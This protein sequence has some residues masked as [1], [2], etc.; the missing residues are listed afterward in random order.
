MTKYAR[1]RTDGAVECRFQRI[2]FDLPCDIPTLAQQL[3]AALSP[4]TGMDLSAIQT[5]PGTTYADVGLR[6]SLFGGQA[7]L[8]VRA[9]RS[10]VAFSRLVLDSEILLALECAELVTAA[11][12]ECWT[13]FRLAETRIKA[14][15]WLK[16]R[17]DAASA[18]ALLASAISEHSKPDLTAYPGAERVT[19]SL[20][21]RVDNSSEGWSW[22]MTL[23]RSAIREANLYTLMESSFQSEG[24]FSKLTEQAKFLSDA[25]IRYLEQFNLAPE[26]E[27]ATTP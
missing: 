11:L 17:D 14:S 5:L 22:T 6:A 2:R 10:L 24:R 16:F 15:S 18:D 3:H 20:A 7:S 21:C 12:R 4:R 9:D 25:Y 27:T 1:I 8:E 13:D 26:N 23:E 19:S